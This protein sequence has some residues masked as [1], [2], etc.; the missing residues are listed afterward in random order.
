MRGAAPLAGPAGRDGRVV[1]GLDAANCDEVAPTATASFSGLLC[2]P[3]EGVAQNGQALPYSYRIEPHCEQLFITCPFCAADVPFESS[4]GRPNT[5]TVM[6][7][8]YGMRNA[9]VSRIRHVPRFHVI[10]Y[11][12]FVVTFVAGVLGSVFVFCITRN[13]G[14]FIFP[15]NRSPLPPDQLAFGLGRGRANRFRFSAAA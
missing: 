9:G 14:A 11:R 5:T 7:F 8:V 15:A 10:R 12:R 3:T 4:K 6:R 2:E 1:R 13:D